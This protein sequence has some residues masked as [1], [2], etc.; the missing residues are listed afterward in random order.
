M[1][2]SAFEDPDSY[3]DIGEAVLGLKP[4][5]KLKQKQKPTTEQEHYDFGDD[6]DDDLEDQPADYWAY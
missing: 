6:D 4:A 5:P 2:S 3:P 1:G